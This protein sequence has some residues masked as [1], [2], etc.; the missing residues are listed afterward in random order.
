MK[1]RRKKKSMGDI[2][3]D[4]FIYTILIFILIV[5]FYPIWYVVAASFSTSTE[6]VR[7]PGLFLWPKNF[8]AGAYAMVFKDP[9]IVS[10]F[11]NTLKY[12][13]L[14]LP[15]NIVLTLMCGYFMAS[16]GMKFKKPIVMMIL[17]TMF[18]SGG[19]IP[20]YLNVRDLGL[21]DTIW[22]LVLPGAMT[23]YNAIICK[24]SIEAIPESLSESA[25][26]DGANDAQILWK[27][28]VPLIKPTLAVL[29]L[30][31]GVAHWNSWFQA[32]IY[33]KDDINMPLQNILRG[34]LLENQMAEAAGGDYFNEYTES[35]KYAAIVVSTFP[36]LCV[37]PFLQ[38]YFAKGALV[39]A[40]K[41]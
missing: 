8:T 3:L 13:L 19:M 29:V 28:I 30:Y 4:I 40:V 22:A 10:G 33:I 6:L 12:L 35:I 37:Y 17:F 31:Y 32:S 2:F 38:K 14:S 7:N 36:I 39:G 25:F 5:T 1:R 16:T 20:T 41:G 11:I 26:I 18:F 9:L 24:T 23:V 34:L 21:T 15:L 27:I